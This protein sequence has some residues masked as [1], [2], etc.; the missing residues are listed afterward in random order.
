LVLVAV[1]EHSKQMEQKDL[2]LHL[3]L[4]LLLVVVKPNGII[5]AHLVDR[6][7]VAQ[8]LPTQVEQVIKVHILQ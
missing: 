3:I 8:I 2:T 5:A 6:V 4:I 1:A 7:A